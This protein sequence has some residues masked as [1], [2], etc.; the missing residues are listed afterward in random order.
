VKNVIEHIR[1]SG[2]IIYRIIACTGILLPLDLEEQMIQCFNKTFFL[3]AFLAV[4]AIASTAR[5]AL[6]KRYLACK[7]MLQ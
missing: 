4:L 7:D 3:K 1:V 6:R 2:I 5:K